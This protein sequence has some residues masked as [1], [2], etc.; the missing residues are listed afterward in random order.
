MCE[1]VDCYATFVVLHH[2]L[3]YLVKYCFIRLF[4]RRHK[5]IIIIELND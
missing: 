1:T 5:D 3:F 2:S 4:A